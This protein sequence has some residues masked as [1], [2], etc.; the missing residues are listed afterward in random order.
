MHVFCCQKEFPS[1][2]Q[3][4]KSCWARPFINTCG[5]WLETTHSN[6][7]HR[8]TYSKPYK[9]PTSPSRFRGCHDRRW[10]RISSIEPGC[11]LIC[12]VRHILDNINPKELMFVDSKRS[13]IFRYEQ[14]NVAFSCWT[15]AN[16]IQFHWMFANA[17][18][19]TLVHFVTLH[20]RAYPAS[21]S[22]YLVK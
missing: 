2:P 22:G 21:A 11:L 20:R 4:K 5:G 7:S 3:Q 15:V 19:R 16:V 17:T 12:M 8:M 13:S 1:R 18:V 9:S 10:S 14:F 6:S